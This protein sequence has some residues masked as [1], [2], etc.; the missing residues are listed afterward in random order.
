MKKAVKGMAKNVV[1]GRAGN[2]MSTSEQQPQQPQV[3]RVVTADSP[4]QSQRP[5]LPPAG[6]AAA[7]P[8]MGVFTA[9][10]QWPPEGPSATPQHLEV[11]DGTPVS[12]PVVG[13]PVTT[14]VATFQMSSEAGP[15]RAAVVD[16][17][18]R[19]EIP[20]PTATS[21]QYTAGY[22]PAIPHA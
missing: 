11:A 8:T 18:Q 19:Q 9:L 14:S 7:V 2:Q 22:Y 16:S 10:P 21:S 15:L 12:G 6:L 13:Q 3:Q 20:Y 1:M 17:H 4:L 5:L